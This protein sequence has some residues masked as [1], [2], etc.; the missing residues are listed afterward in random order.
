MVFDFI[1]N[2]SS[3]NCIRYT[4]YEYK[5]LTQKDKLFSGKFDP[6]NLEAAINAYAQQGWRMIGCS[7][8]DISGFGRSRQEFIAVFE[9]EVR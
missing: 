1:N 5:I 6:S 3:N 8:A 2:T 7:T 4:Q 9:R